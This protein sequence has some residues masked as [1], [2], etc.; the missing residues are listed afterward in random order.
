MSENDDK[1]SRE[2]KEI[3]G[4]KTVQETENKRGE[5]GRFVTGGPGGPGRGKKA[6]D[7]LELAEDL[8]ELVEAV[9][10]EG[11]TGSPDLKDKLNAAKL[12]L[13]VEARKKPEEEADP[14]HPV[15]VG[16]SGLIENLA[17][18]GENGFDVMKRMAEVCPGCEKLGSKRFDIDLGA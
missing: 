3:N 10:R 4:E 14:C 11:I 2:N 9:A 8:L 6:N 7:D 17:G 5:D 1:N 15:V 13:N 16:W 12:A 18:V